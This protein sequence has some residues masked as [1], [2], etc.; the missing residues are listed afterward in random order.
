MSEADHKPDLPEVL[1]RPTLPRALFAVAMATLLLLVGVGLT[2]RYGVL[3]PQVRQL[4][5]ARTDGLKIGRFGRLKLEGLSGD[6]WRDLRVR[7]LTVRDD[8][9]VWLEA[10][11]VH[12]VWRYEQLFR[13]RFDADLIQADALKLLKRPKLGPS[14]PDTGMPVS[15][16]IRKAATQLDLEPA[17]SGER[18]LYDVALSLDVARMGG[19]R[20]QVSAKSLLHPGDYLDVDF[21]LPKRGAL[22]VLATAREAQGGAI[23]GALGLSPRLP[24]EL[25]I[26][27]D[28]TVSEGRFH[29]RATSGPAT[30]L[31]AQGAWTPQGGQ[32][33]GRLLLTASTL[34]APYADR[35]GSDVL[36]GLAGRKS[37]PDVYALDARLRSEGLTVHAWGPGDLGKRTLSPQGAHLEAQAASLSRLI[38]RGP[39]AGATQLAGVLKGDATAWRFVGDATVNDFET[40]NYGLARISGPL[41][42]GRAKGDWSLKARL[43]GAGGRGSGY[44]AAILGGAPTLALEVDRLGNGQLLLK[45]LDGVGRGLKVSASGGRSLLGAMTFK[46]QADVSNLAAAGAGASGA[47]SIGWQAAQ[48]KVGAPWTFRLDARGDGFALGRAQLDRLLGAKPRL[49]VEAAWDAGK[50]SVGK[51]S[52]DGANLG[53]TVAGVLSPD[54]SLSFKADWTASGPFELGPVEVTGKARGTGSVTGALA[55]PKLD[56]IADLDQVDLPRLP[57]KAARLSLTFQRQP[58]GSSGLVALT[59]TSA[60]GPARGRSAFRFPDGGVDLTDLNVDAGGVKAQG[61]LSLRRGAPSAADLTVDITRGALIDAGR[62]A[63]TLKIL[64]QAGGARA[65][66]N[67]RGEG[68]RLPGSEITLKTARLT[69]DGP[70]ARLPYA[71]TAQGGSPQGAWGLD[72]KGALADGQPGYA[73]TFAGS[74][75]LGGRELRTTEPAQ[76]RFGGDQRSA[77]LRLAGTDGGRIDLDALMRGGAADVK[78]RLAGLNLGLFDPDFAGRIDANLAITGSGARLDGTLDATLAQ[79][80]ARGAPASQGMDGTLKGRLAGETLAL[81]VATS[82][83]QGLKANASVVLPTETSA[84]PFR[85]AVARLK[86]LQGR[87]AAEGEVRPLWDLLVGGERELSGVVRTQGTLSGTLAAP[88]ATGQVAVER[89]R[90]DDGASGLSLRD[91]VLKADFTQDAVNVGEAHGDDGR[92]G[93]VSGQGRISLQ[94]DGISSFRLDLKGFRLIDNELATA[95][96]TGQ[97]TVNR[98]ADGKVKLTGDLTIDRADVAAN[99]PT[100]SGVVAMDVKEVN[101]PGDLPA[102]LPGAETRGQGWLLDVTL[103]A[104]RRVMLRGRG[105]DVELS[106]DAHV[107]GSTTYPDL[108]GTARVVRGSYDFAGKRFDFDTTSVVF[109]STHA[110]NIR[111]QLDATRDD[112]TLSVTARIRGTAAKP[113]I[114]FTS[115]PSLP[116][117]EVLAQLL[118]G[119]S[120]SQL[121]AV[122]AAQLASALSGLAGG[123]GLD[124]IGNVR[125]FAR[126]DRLA[127]GGDQT[128]GVTLSGGKYVTED[129]YLELTG[130]GRE[131]PSAQVEWRVRRNLSILSRIAGQAGNKIAVRWRRDY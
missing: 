66:A 114:T 103:K 47:A 18:G 96:A 14:G 25:D 97:A 31:V 20:G 102:S 57:L 94:R 74:G 10:D 39:K 50:L 77:R 127:F 30:P 55:T 92:G 29:A 107:G 98:S 60:Y 125:S 91:V 69:A 8:E 106:L 56:L 63:G 104:P 95:S 2:T 5:E 82:N 34:T 99:P 61:S 44:A 83:A 75:K 93:Q 11:N 51:A 64:D 26:R 130:G 81:D 32:A 4:I 121:S 67:L 123:G 73:L 86:P 15:F 124:V 41:E 122:E 87:F 128:T 72:G 111:L 19:Q 59:G 22:K 40:S 89:G 117:D 108:S 3:V 78:A 109:L 116:N 110:E 76:V 79:A 115:S 42:L 35:L 16:H 17:F 131:G 53:A 58:D 119:R 54:R 68:L 52:L 33:G 9:G 100:P 23:A 46:G 118:F 62:I 38:G 88:H 49:Q 129:V 7:R 70:L 105:L 85:I 65:S 27:A 90:F 12:L 84:A 71:V 120:A 48:A 24:F 1:K 36:F 101:R 112:T 80:R 21:A 6:I 28:G 113:E 43:A 13:R 126:L 37:G 45:R